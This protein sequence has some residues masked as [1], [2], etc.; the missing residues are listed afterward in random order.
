MRVCQDHYT[1]TEIL[2][3]ADWKIVFNES[4]KTKLEKGI[5]I[6]YLEGGEE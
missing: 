4:M 1:Y 5:C 3:P 2:D 6:K